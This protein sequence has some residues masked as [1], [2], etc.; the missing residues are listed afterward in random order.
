MPDTTRPEKKTVADIWIEVQSEQKRFNRVIRYMTAALLVAAIIAGLAALLSLTEFQNLQRNY[1]TQINVSSAKSE[2]Q[3]SQA[4]SDRHAMKT[5]LLRLKEENGQNR[6]YAY[7]PREAD[8]AI[9]AAGE[10]KTQTLDQLI[11]SALMFSKQSVAGDLRLNPSTS[12]LIES[13][14]E[15]AHGREE[16]TMF[17]RD[18][19]E[20]MEVALLDWQL[21]TSPETR[22]RW[23]RFSSTSNKSE[24]RGYAYAALAH[25]HYRRASDAS[26]RLDW[27][28]GCQDTTELVEQAKR[29]AIE[30]MS[31]AL[32]AG[33][34]LRKNGNY[35]KAFRSF[36]DALRQLGQE[37][38]SSGTES[39]S[40]SLKIRI[41]ASHGAGT[42]L[43]PFAISLSD[44]ERD[45]QQKLEQIDDIASRLPES[46]SDLKL[47]IAA[48]ETILEVSEH[49]LHHAIM[50]RKQRNEGE[51]GEF[52][53]KENLGYVYLAR[54]DWDQALSHARSIDTRMTRAWNLVVYAIAL[55]ELE[56]DESDEY[57]NIRTKIGL[58]PTEDFDTVEIGKLLSSQQRALFETILSTEAG[59][60]APG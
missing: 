26:P 17:T 30:S 2:I 54:N 4:E 6:I 57:Q 12:Y 48:S 14:L 9:A 38:N 23:M 3:I 60:A 19:A 21:P 35:E 37:P 24:L 16:H 42:T 13:V 7:L 51:V 15:L 53:T 33:E 10:H 29:L 43:I 25:Y 46:F 39:R 56:Q 52:G 45:K 32:A 11:A 55:H 28:Q 1:E 31:L 5:E 27:N 36:V 49:F 40:P 58:M 18:E 8:R 47:K 41:D 20:F 44:N 34:C 50:L 22:I 59:P